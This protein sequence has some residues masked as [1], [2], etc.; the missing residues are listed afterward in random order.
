MASPPGVCSRRPPAVPPMMRVTSS[1]GT[2]P[3]R[4]PRGGVRRAARSGLAAS[5]GSAREVG[6]GRR[7]ARSM[8]SSSRSTESS[9]SPERPPL[10]SMPS[11]LPSRRCSRSIRESSK[12]SR[13]PATA[14]SRSIVLD[15][16]STPVTSR[17]SPAWPP[18]PIRPRSWCSW[19]TPNRSASRITITVALGTSTPTSI[20]VVET[21]TSTSPAA[22]ARITASLSSGAIRPCS[23]PTRSP[24]SGPSASSGPTSSTAAGAALVRRAPSVVGRPR[25]GSRRR[26]PGGRRRPPRG[27]APR[28]G[29]ARPAAPAGRRSSAPRRGRPGAR[30]SVE[31]SR[32]PNTVIATVRGI[33]VAVIT[34]TCGGRAGLGAQRGALLD[35]EAVLL[36]DDHQPEVGELHV[37]LEQGVR[38]D[39]DA[40]L[41]AGRARPARC[42]GR[43]RPATRSAAPPGSP[44][45]APPSMPPSARSPSIAVIERWCCWASTSVGASSA[46]WPPESTPGASPAARPRSCRSRPRPGAAGASGGRGRARRRSRR[47]PHAG[48][49]VSAN[50]SRS[51]NRSRMPPATPGRGSATVPSMRGPAPG[52]HGLGDERLVVLEPVARPG[53]LAA[54]CRGGGSSAAPRVRR[55][56]PRCGADGLGQRVGHVLD[57]VEREA[58]SSPR[59]A[60]C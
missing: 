15:P 59:A 41:A 29:R 17:H 16:G 1:P 8:T 12:P 35:A 22:N 13:V 19:E 36:V 53:Q 37:L 40:G 21:S 32:S 47:R 51:S 50:G 39:H 9:L 14:T 42:A 56:G 44:P 52:E 30:L 7:R 33:G 49:S 20:T 58:R 4:S 43:R 10:C 26:R 60:R 27:P 54:S 2:R 6:R 38:A 18:R 31:V 45:S 3:A 55:P 24:A 5:S 28:R 57:Q 25:S 11:T 23:S 34:S 48:P 46:A